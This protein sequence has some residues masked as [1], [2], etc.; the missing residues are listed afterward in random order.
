MK[1]NDR[2]ARKI[3]ASDKVGEA[4]QVKGWVLHRNSLGGRD[5]AF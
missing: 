2:E 1:E 4:T 5:G 3:P